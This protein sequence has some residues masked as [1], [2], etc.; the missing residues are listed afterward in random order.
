[1]KQFANA[2]LALVDDWPLWAQ[3]AL[4]PPILGLVMSYLSLLLYITTINMWWSHLTSL[5]DIL[6]TATVFTVPA[7]IAIFTRV[8]SV[9]IITLVSY[10][11][12]GIS[13]Y[14]FDYISIWGL[15]T[16]L[17]GLAMIFATLQ[18]LEER[19]AASRRSPQA[20]TAGT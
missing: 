20:R 15:V 19:I 13:I 7:W 1:M 5:K 6:F 14:G 16:Q 11:V 10:G 8:R 4:V 18:V 12:A 9:A 3:R 2:A 17:L